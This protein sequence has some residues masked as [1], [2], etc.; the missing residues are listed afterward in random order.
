MSQDAEA[1]RTQSMTVWDLVSSAH[2]AMLGGGI[3]SFLG[4][5][6]TVV[7]YIA[8][9]EM[10]RGLLAGEPPSRAW[11]CLAVALVAML[12]RLFTYMGALGATHLAEANLRNEL[13]H[14]LVA[15]LGKVPLGWYTQNSSG[16]IRQAIV[17]DTRQIHSLVAHM[18]GDLA[19][20]LGSLL[21]GFAYLLWLDPRLAGF[22]IVI[23]VAFAVICVMPGM[24][25]MSQ[26]AQDYIQAS[27][28]LSAITV[29]LV[30][31][32]KEVKNFGVVDAV[33][34][35]FEETRKRHVNASM[36]WMR[37]SGVG[38]AL[39]SA[40][41]QPAGMLALTIGCGYWFVSMGW[42]EPLTVLAF[43]LVWVG[44]PEGL[45]TLMQMLQS[46]TAS[47][48]AARAS[49]EILTC[50]EL[51]QVDRPAELTQ[52]PGLVEFDDVVFS[53]EPGTPVIDH[54]SLT[55]RPGTVTALVGPSGGGKSTLARL[56][57]R[58]W[59]VDSGQVRVG[60]LDVRQQTEAQLMSSMSLV[61]QDIMTV[62]DTVAANISLGKPDASRGEI[63]EAARQAHIHDRI[64]ALPQ[65]YDT[66]LGDGSGFL[67]G[68][69]AQRLTIA[70]AFLSAPPILILDE[71]TAQADSH[72]ELAI[73]RAL[74]ALA[75]G[76]TV[77]MIAHRL[78]TV[79]S[80]DQIAVIRDGRI[81]E[82]GTH[83][84]LIAAGGQYWRMWHTQQESMAGVAR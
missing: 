36:A 76:R 15:K 66:V 23:V 19:N 32:I 72:S 77:I 7:P 58:F 18:S 79:R 54:L 37:S 8:L 35:R 31:G 83:E 40:L 46:L 1:P 47:R 53:Y 50:P 2:R 73:Q 59:D 17:N 10:A 80:A 20:A 44:I 29:E 84:E 62:H 24:R 78:S 74:S 30:D 51:A 25:T 16:R 60:G 65:G 75:V 48:Q 45:L 68:G 27:S 12:V 55:C 69:E 9:V 6:L 70:R 21:T 81:A 5:A 82:A 13:R 71:A 42:S 33:F 4:A 38:L 41:V 49:I 67:S 57:A 63:E 64:M 56:V 14:A 3:V 11:L 43:A 26:A 28:E 39:V 34:G 52:A 22:L 61:F